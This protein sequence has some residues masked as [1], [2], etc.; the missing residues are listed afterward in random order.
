MRASVKICTLFAAFALCALTFCSCGG[1]GRDASEAALQSIGAE[2]AGGPNGGSA[3]PDA[4]EAAP[5]TVG[6][7]HLLTLGDSIAYGYG[8]SEPEKE[9]YSALLPALLADRYAV[10]DENCGVSGMTGAELVEYLR[11][12][13]APAGL[14]EADAALISIGGNDVLGFLPEALAPVGDLSTLTELLGRYALYLLRPTSAL[15]PAIG[16]LEDVLETIN[17]CFASDSFRQRLEE[18]AARLHDAV[19][20]AAQAIRAVN[21]SAVLLISTIYNP[22]KGVRVVL[23]QLTASVELSEYGDI[24]VRRLNDAI[25]E[26]AEE[27]GLRVVDVYARFEASGEQLVNAAFSLSPLRINFDVHPNAAGHA[28]IA[29][30]YEDAIRGID[31]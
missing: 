18:A 16:E 4:S 6:P 5:G 17:A 26:A 21:P 30:A 11:G 28:Q 23:P 7:L 13:D 31:F 19:C 9:R 29:A 22:Y 14:R 3:S 10:V 12:P 1:G 8:L 27:E 2:S 25:R 20:G 24:A 15:A